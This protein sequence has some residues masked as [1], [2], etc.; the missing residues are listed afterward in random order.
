MLDEKKFLRSIQLRNLGFTMVARRPV[1]FREV[2]NIG[3]ADPFYTLAG[4]I[5][6]QKGEYSNAQHSFEILSRIDPSRVAAASPH[7][8]RLLDALTSA[9]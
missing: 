5:A 1:F 8:S 4:T 7:A 9:V 3:T 2:I 6:R